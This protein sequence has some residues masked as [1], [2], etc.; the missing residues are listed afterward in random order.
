M[1]IHIYIYIYV[2]GKVNSDPGI[3]ELERSSWRRKLFCARL[4]AESPTLK[5]KLWVDTRKGT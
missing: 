1:Y 3:L 4:G 2:S 5:L